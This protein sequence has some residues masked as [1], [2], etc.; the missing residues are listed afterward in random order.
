MNSELSIIIPFFN[1]TNETIACVRS[2]LNS[3][4]AD[5]LIYILD[6]AS[7]E[8]SSAL[9]SEFEQNKNIKIISNFRNRGYTRNVSIGLNLVDSEFL[10]ILNSDTLVPE[11]WSYNLL[12]T[13]KSNTRIAAVGPMSNSASYQS[14]PCLMDSNSGSFSLNN[15]LGFEETDREDVS[16]ALQ[17]LSQGLI[18][19]VSI[20]NGFCTIFR[21][22]LLEEIGGF[23]TE[24][25]PDG[26]GEEND[27]CIRLRANGY[28]LAL[29]LGVFVHHQKSKSFGH[30]RKKSLSMR[31]TLKLHELYGKGVMS[32][33]EMQL[34]NSVSLKLIRK[35]MALYLAGRGK[36]TLKHFVFEQG[37]LLS[38]NK[39]QNKY[40]LVT[41]SGGG[42]YSISN[43]VIS[44]SEN[45]GI[46]HLELSCNK[47][48]L[49]ISLPK[50]IIMTIDFSKPIAS[51]L[52]ALALLSSRHLVYVMKWDLPQ[53]MQKKS[54]SKK[55]GWPEDW[56]LDQ[57]DHIEFDQIHYDFNETK[58]NL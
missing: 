22:S 35:L 5:C 48:E 20:L 51:S 11:N 36:S 53:N 49:I 27:V 55:E 2:I 33:I 57:I 14:F 13:L 34:I 54:L 43:Q 45:E 15:G 52:L 25:F 40:G 1:A 17:F 32:R 46:I 23:N 21:R 28:H 19:D 56:G 47:D 7:T 18:L 24:S 38:L 50:N 12:Q 31:G 26:Y 16:Q 37:A 10:C 6:D 44:R 9:I 29:N 39:A 58:S 30:K 42:T 41:L 8:G 3:D 4:A